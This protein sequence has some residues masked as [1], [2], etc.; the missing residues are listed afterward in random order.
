M[1]AASFG[2]AK[3]GIPSYAQINGENP[4]AGGANGNSQQQTVETYVWPPRRED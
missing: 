3:S 2:E 1:D 4:T